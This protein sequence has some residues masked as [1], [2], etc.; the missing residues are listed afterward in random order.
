MTEDHRDPPEGL[1]ETD[2]QWSPATSSGSSPMPS[3]AEVVDPGA[4]TVSAVPSEGTR[5]GAEPGD[6]ALGA[7]TDQ[8][9]RLL[10]GELQNAMADPEAR[11]GRYV[12]TGT[13]GRGGMGV[14]HRGWDPYLRRDVAIKT[15]KEWNPGHEVLARFMR[16]AR[17]AARLQHPCI[18]GVQEVIEHEGKPVIIMD[19]VEG[20]SFNVHIKRGVSIEESVGV[21]RDIALALHYAHERGIIHRDVKPQNILVSSEGIPQ[22]TDFGLARDELCDRGALTAAGDIL[23]TPRFMAPEQVDPTAGAIGPAT[24]VYAL[25]A[26]LYRALTKKSVSD[27]DHPTQLMLQILSIDPVSCRE[28]NP[29][30]SPALDAVVMRCLR[31]DV[32]NAFSSASKRSSVVMFAS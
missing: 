14:V 15:L 27:S 20:K 11:I 6:H 7:I 18:V 28:H 26:T 29:N 4:A 17:A 31:T 10:P 23:G 2:T 3:E 12:I 13:L 16:E 32:S 8:S 5:L 24:D 9:L 25:G 30:V 19:L 1:E 21:V 22:L